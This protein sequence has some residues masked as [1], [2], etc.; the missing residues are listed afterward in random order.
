MTLVNDG[1][2][3]DF[4]KYALNEAGFGIRGTAGNS[5]GDSAVPF[6]WCPP[7]SPKSKFDDGRP[8]RMLTLVDEFTRECPVSY[9]FHPGVENLTHTLQQSIRV[10]RLMKE[11][12]GSTQHSV[13]I[14]VI[15]GISRNEEHAHGGM[16]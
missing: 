8:F 5:G 6:V 16:L 2:P 3:F 7:K 11:L 14:E 9:A 12:Y 10:E 15:G 1:C 13:S 4:A